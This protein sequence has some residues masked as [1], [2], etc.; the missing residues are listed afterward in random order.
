MNRRQFLAATGTATATAVLRP[1]FAAGP[2]A[3]PIRTVWNVRS[4]EGFDAISFLGPLSGD[5]F[6]AQHY[7]AEIAAFAPRLP[8]GTVE[9]IK[10]LKD[11]ASAK[12]IMMTPFLDVVFSSGQDADIAT[13]V[14]AIDVAETRLKPPFAVSPY[15][16]QGNW[17]W[18]MGARAEL[19]AL[20]LALDAA[21]FAAFRKEAFASTEST[22]LPQL[23]AKLAQYDVTAEQARMVGRP[24]DPRIDVVVLHFCKPHGIKVQGQ[25]FLAAGSYDDDTWV[26]VSV[27]EMMHPPLVMDGPVA[28]RVIA[29]IEADPVLA[30]AIKEHD[31]RFGYTD[32]AGV[33]NEDLV[34]ALD[35][36]ICE[37]LGVA[38]P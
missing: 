24:F 14:A 26:F 5:D 15:W 9:R 36:M 1:A 25:Q 4:S 11:G 29:L 27:H 7:P 19:R 21:G 38:R 10:A 28:K 32:A 18:F 6:Y 23:R 34:Q 37:R 16:D 12:S 20:L 2:P 3:K 35:Q 13:L 17:D 30:R 22:R 8:K 31:P 33:L